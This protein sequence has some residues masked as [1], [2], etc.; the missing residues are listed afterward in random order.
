MVKMRQFEAW[1]A[2]EHPA[3]IVA[4]TLL[5]G[6]VDVASDVTAEAFSR[7]LEH[8]DDVSAMENPAGWTYVVAVNLLRRR[9]HRLRLEAGALLR[10]TRDGPPPQLA[11][12]K[13][14]IYRAVRSLPK[15][16]R[17]AVVLRYFGG[18]SEAEVAKAMGVSVGT[19]SASLSQARQRLSVLLADYVELP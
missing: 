16:A 1:Y 8:W 5:T 19:A 14:D 7:A 18:L 9:W 15:R 12:T 6:D 13:V 4:V 2:Q 3:L 11:D 10:H 17:A